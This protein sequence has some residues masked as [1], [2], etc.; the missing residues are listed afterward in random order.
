MAYLDNYVKAR[1]AS[2]REQ[3]SLLRGRKRQHVI[4][5][6][7]DVLDDW[8][9]SRWQHEGEARAGV[10]SALCMS[11]HGWQSSDTEAATIIDTALRRLGSGDR[12]TWIEGQNEYRDL[13]I[14]C[15]DCGNRLSALRLAGGELFCSPLCEENAARYRPQIARYAKRLAYSK[16]WYTVWKATAPERCCEGCGAKYRSPFPGQHFCSYD[17]AHK[18]QRNPERHRQCSH[19]EKPFVCRQSRGRKQKYC[20]V[21]CRI[22]AWGVQQ[23]ECSVCSNPF[24]AKHPAHCCSQKCRNKHAN[25]ERKR[26]APE[27]PCEICGSVFKS[28]RGASTCSRSCRSELRSRTIAAKQVSAF[29]LIF[30]Q[31]LTAVVFDGW[32]RR[33]A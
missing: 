13:R 29:I 19:C 1:N 11:G 3:H 17:C 12:P 22:A 5:E 28:H 25:E 31:P 26:N 16:A 10:R 32:F 21:E 7:M 15:A 20:S 8:R 33:A 6:V 24:E 14:A 18:A 23:Y 9:L 30:P 4:Q 27:V 2:L